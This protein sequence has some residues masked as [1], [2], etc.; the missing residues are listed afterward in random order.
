MVRI[1]DGISLLSVNDGTEIH[2]VDEFGQNQKFVSTSSRTVA[3]F[4]VPDSKP[5]HSWLTKLS[6]PFTCAAVCCG[7]SD[8]ILAVVKHKQIYRWSVEC[9]DPLKQKPL[10]TLKSLI[11]RIFRAHD[12]QILVLMMNGALRWLDHATRSP[13]TVREGCLEDGEEIRDAWLWQQGAKEEV[14]TKEH[15]PCY[16]ICLIQEQ[17][18]MKY[19]LLVHNVGKIGTEEGE[20]KDAV[21]I[22]LEPPVSGEDETPAILSA[23][24]LT[25]SSAILYT[26]WEGGHVCCTHIPKSKLEGKQEPQT[27][28][29]H[30][31][32]TVSG[33]E[34]EMRIAAI[35]DRLVAIAGSQRLPSSGEHKATLSV[36]DTTY[37][38]LQAQRSLVGEEEEGLP[39]FLKVIAGPHFPRN[40]INLLVQAGDWACQ[41]ETSKKPRRKSGVTKETAKSG[42]KLTALVQKVCD[43]TKTNTAKKFSSAVQ[44]LLKSFQDCVPDSSALT[45]VLKSVVRR[46]E[47]NTGFWSEKAL[48]DI[49]A[50]NVLAASSCPEFVGML[51]RRGEVSLLLDCLSFMRDFPELSL[52]QCLQ[53]FLSIDEDKLSAM[54]TSTEDNNMVVSTSNPDEDVISV[55]R[56]QLVD[57]ALS[58]PFTDSFML[59]A[60]KHLHFKE[61]VL[62][63]KYLYLLL[64]NSFSG[65]MGA[66]SEVSMD[67]VVDWIGVLLDA[68]FAQLVLVP[69]VRPL[70]AKLQEAVKQQVAFSLE[71]NAIQN[72]LHHASSPKSRV[73]SQPK[74]ASQSYSIEILK[75]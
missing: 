63:L 65:K 39:S 13:G 64:T 20:S 55:A 14:G 40:K 45:L 67:N 47:E 72:L 4:K 74:N 58:K 61:V 33:S 1:E 46:I 34:Q 54:D 44:E 62:L 71:V 50:T 73:K 31:K 27:L 30:L 21:R 37:G 11:S 48:H 53:V 35:N 12:N 17:T 32:F 68:H 9:A 10:V 36:W 66:H 38:T 24:C 70:I 52:V 59:D 57:E 29:C 43:Q 6:S 18:K 41:E 49:I 69:D 8:E 7:E 56:R 51:A 16:V 23:S 28:V 3:V 5:L 19:S 2:N 15:R 22:H 25:D 75:I 60:V 26:L 42:T